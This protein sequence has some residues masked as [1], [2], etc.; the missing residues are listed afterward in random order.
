MSKATED[1]ESHQQAAADGAGGLVIWNLS[2]PDLED[3]ILDQQ[4]SDWTRSETDVCQEG[5]KCCWCFKQ[6]PP[7]PVEYVPAGGISTVGDGLTRVGPL[8]DA[9]YTMASANPF[10]NVGRSLVKAT[11]PLNGAG[12][13][14]ARSNPLRDAAI[15]LRRVVGLGKPKTWDD[16]TE[17]EVHKCGM[18]KEEAKKLID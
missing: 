14:L 16:L 10:H 6:A 11:K 7:P 17:E 9:G 13:S 4:E 3:S 12:K 1:T 2:S 15:S 8:R 18:T 5:R